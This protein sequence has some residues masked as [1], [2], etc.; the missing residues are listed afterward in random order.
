MIQ[1]IHPKKKQNNR[2]KRTIQMVEQRER[3]KKCRY[4]PTDTYYYTKY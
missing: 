2:K 1:V 3:T 4:N